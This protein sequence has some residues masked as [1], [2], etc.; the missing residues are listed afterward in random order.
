MKDTDTIKEL[1][2]QATNTK[3]MLDRLNKAGY[4]ITMD[5]LIRLALKRNDL[6]YGTDREDKK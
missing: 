6:E 2:Q 5:E 3:Q 4:G 1:E